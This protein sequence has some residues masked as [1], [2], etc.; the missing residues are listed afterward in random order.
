MNK[1]EGLR[2]C[3]GQCFVER[4][5][6]EERNVEVHL[7]SQTIPLGP[8]LFG[9]SAHQL[10]DAHE[11]ILL[12]AAGE[13]GHSRVQFRNDSSDSEKVHGGVVVAPT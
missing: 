10:E 2:G 11:L 9:R 3:I 12:G 13:E 8:L 4:D 5:C 1:A 7:C 6:F